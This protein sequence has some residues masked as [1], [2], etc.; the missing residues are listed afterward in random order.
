MSVSK[1]RV[2]LAALTAVVIS[3][4]ATVA[5]A[6]PTKQKPSMCVRASWERNVVVKRLSAQAAGRDIC[7]RGVKYKSGNVVQPSNAQKAK[8]LRALRALAA[9]APYSLIKYASKPALP[10]AGTMTPHYRP[11]GLASCIVHHESRGI[12]TASNGS[13]WGIAQWTIEAWLRHGGGRFASSPLGATYEE[14][15][16]VLS[17]GLSRYG[18]VDWCPFDPC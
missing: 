12:P 10:P 14:Q 11:T 18:C 9:P 13:H 5:T 15:L 17:N 16:L 7:N 4:P 3:A 8:Y 6:A 2:L 1:S